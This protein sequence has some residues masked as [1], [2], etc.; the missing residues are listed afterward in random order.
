MPESVQLGRILLIL[1]GAIALLGLALIIWP[2]IPFLGRLPG[3][4]NLRVGPVSVF[5]PLVTCLLLS[6][7]LT[8]AV[9]LVAW[10]LRRG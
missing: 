8:I 2:R 9:N 6:V 3:D 7:V 4:I 1:G 5:A 10:W